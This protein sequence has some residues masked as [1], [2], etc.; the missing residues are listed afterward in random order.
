M[1]PIDGGNPDIEIDGSNN[2]YVFYQNGASTCRISKWDGSIFTDHIDLSNDGA[3]SMSATYGDMVVAGNGDLH[4]LIDRTM[5][6]MASS[7]DMYHNRY[8][9]SWSG[10]TK[11]YEGN[12]APD[13]STKSPDFAFADGNNKIHLTF[14]V[15]GTMYYATDASGSWV[16]TP[17]EA[18]DNGGERWTVVESGL[19]AHTFYR[20]NTRQDLHT[21]SSTD[22]FSSKTKVV[23][24]SGNITVGNV[25]IDG[26]NR[27]HIVYSNTTDGTA[28][29]KTN[30]SGSW[31]EEQLTSTGFTNLRAEYV[32]LNGADIYVL[33]YN[34]TE[35][36]YYFKRKVSGSWYDGKIFEADG[37]NSFVIDSSNSKIYMP[38]QG[39]SD[40]QHIYYYVE[41]IAAFFGASNNN[42]TISIDNTSL[43]YTEND[44]AVQI[45]PSATIDDTDGD[46][47][48]DGGTLAVQ[49][50]ANA[51]AA[52]E[53][54]I[55]DNVVGT[56]NTDG[57][58]L[59]NGVTVI[60]VLSASQGTVT[61]NS[62]LTVTFN[63][64]ASNE[65]VQQTVRAVHYR[66][67]SDNPGTANRTVRFT[68]TDNNMGSNSD[69]RTIAV[70][71][72]NDNPTGISLSNAS[73]DEN[74]PANTVVG[75]IST[76]DPDN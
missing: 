36:L 34:T 61:N 35:R 24:T 11:V 64:N 26:S 75:T 27:F 32:Q 16:T 51:E 41:D 43:S 76:T 25:L 13:S 56:I 66:N 21:A 40:L 50:T 5:T 10:F 52:D 12:N 14:E 65:L 72:Q 71:A 54:S 67:S 20:N 22:S 31:V 3:N 63:S 19:T 46:G 37:A 7:G 28:F 2:I 29:Y 8:N 60:G 74:L 45:D 59:Q 68:V 62:A 1:E 55:P 18:V 15:S 4:V 48:W 30:V 38:F 44:P 47:D 39:S 73:V 58:N 9:G 33:M 70:V 69:T 6:A 57:T 49:I 23:D 42:P 17:L 53:I